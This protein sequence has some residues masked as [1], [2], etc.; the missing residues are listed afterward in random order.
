M[1]HRIYTCCLQDFKNI[2]SFHNCTSAKCIDMTYNQIIR[3]FIAVDPSNAIRFNL[4]HA[5]ILLFPLVI[6]GLF[7]SIATIS[8]FIPYLPMLPAQILLTNLLT[9]LPLIALAGDRV[10]TAELSRPRRLNIKDLVFSAMILGLVSAVFD[11]ALFARYRAA[12]PAILQTNWFVFSILAELAT[13]FV[14]RTSLPIWRARAPSS[15]LV[16]AT[17]AAAAVSVA[18]PYLPFGQQLFH[19]VPPAPEDL[20]VIGV[21][22]VLV[23]AMTELVKRLLRR[24]FHTS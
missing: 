22:L 2:N 18:L 24:Y 23:V 15:M 9:D 3:M 7:I 6:L 8:L 13:I 11:L 14:I 16:G 21:L 17:I 20:V 1:I 4:I 19:L 12:P 5:A 10:Q